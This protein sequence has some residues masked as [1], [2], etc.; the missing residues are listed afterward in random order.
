MNQSETAKR[1]KQNVEYTMAAYGRF[2][3]K[4]CGDQG[5]VPLSTPS[6]NGGGVAP[7]ELTCSNGHTDSYDPSQ[8]KYTS[9]KPPLALKLR[10][11]AAGVG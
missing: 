8:I 6:Q 2:E 7:V 11:A 9:S 4:V 3:C 10:R 5:F 1:S